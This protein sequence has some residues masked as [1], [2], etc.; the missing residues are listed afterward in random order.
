MATTRHTI[1]G[2]YDFGPELASSEVDAFFRWLADN[3]INPAS[4]NG[5]ADVVITAD[6]NTKGVTW[7]LTASTTNGQPGTW[8]LTKLPPVTVTNWLRK[9]APKPVDVSEIKAT[10]DKLRDARRREAEAKAEAEELRA[11][12]M[13]YL[14]AR[15]SLTGLIDG[16]PFVQ[17]KQVPMP[18]KFN[19]KAFEAEYPEIAE[20]FTG[21][22]YDQNRLEFI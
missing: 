6:K 20:R 5:G 13:S 18:G 10:L 1:P 22:D 16:Q 19:R 21:A 7:S 12:V 11:E 4:L 17:V 3:A 2:G 15:G 9:F 8:P 14:T